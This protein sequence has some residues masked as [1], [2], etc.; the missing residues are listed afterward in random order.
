MLSK[1]LKWKN[2][3]SGFGNLNRISKSSES[4]AE[5]LAAFSLETED[6]ERE[7]ELQL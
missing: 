1:K 4:A 5:I 6:R 2:K 7:V 3:Q